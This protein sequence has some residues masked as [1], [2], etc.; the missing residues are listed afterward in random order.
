MSIGPLNETLV[1]ITNII[2]RSSTGQAFFPATEKGEEAFDKWQD[3]ILR[4]ANIIHSEWYATDDKCDQALRI[5]EN[6][7]KAVLQPVTYIKEK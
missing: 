2:R 4:S 1:S 3:V 6:A 7:F 5:L